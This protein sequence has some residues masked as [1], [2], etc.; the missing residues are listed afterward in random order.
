MNDNTG[1]PDTVNP[2]IEP[3]ISIVTVCYNSRKTITATI[4]SLLCQTYTNFEYIIIDGVSTDGTVDIVRSYESAFREKAIPF[5][6][7]SEK[8]AGIYEAMNKGINQSNGKLV[9]LLNSDDW[10]CSDTLENIVK[11]YKANPEIGVFHGV[12]KFWKDNNCHTLYGASDLFIGKGI[13]PHH[14]TCFI[15]KSVYNSIGLYDTRYPIASDY[16]MMLRI[17][18]AGVGFL[19]IEKVLTNFSLQGISSSRPLSLDMIAIQKKHGIIS[20]R[21]YYLLSPLYRILNFIYPFLK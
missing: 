17:K 15:K 5:K 21:K 19:M 4:D 8:D 6:W 3:L 2:N 1:Y 16:D 14:A 18:K 13:F 9:A 12:V 11:A 20:K 10:Y 7:T